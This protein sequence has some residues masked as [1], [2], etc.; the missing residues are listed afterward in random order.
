M[1][2]LLT[3]SET[4]NE[5]SKS[6]PDEHR[7]IRMPKEFRDNFMFSLHDYVSLRGADGKI[8]AL[9]ILP[10]YKED[11][12][13]DSSSAYLTSNIF[14]A[15]KIVGKELANKKIQNVELVQGITL[16][17]DPEL[18]LVDAKGN[19]IYANR[20][21]RRFSNVGYDGPMMEFRPMPSTREEG[22]TNNLFSLIV[23]A[24]NHL[25]TFA[26]VKVIN[27][28]PIPQPS[29][30]R[31]VAASSYR[32]VAA[33]F[34]LHFGLP[35]Q[36]LG[37][38]YITKLLARQIVKALDFYVGIPAIIP[39]GGEDFFR[40][41]FVGSAYGKPGNFILDN[42]TLEYRLPGGTLMRHPILAKGILGLGAAVI[43][44]VVSRVKK[45][46]ENYSFLE[47]MLPDKS[48]SIIYP[49]IPPP[50][51]IYQTIVSPNIVPAEAK[52]DIII[53]DVRQMIGYRARA[54]AIEEY[55]KHVK[56][57][58]SSDVE[59]NWRNHYEGQQRSVDVH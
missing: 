47:S 18:F 57:K 45:A 56:T 43:E 41:T 21:F 25:N 22:V 11:A 12:E 38:Q 30:I 54:H 10:A 34:H 58:F 3:V 19:I 26:G 52:L 1:E 15:T 46:T 6:D 55:F 2:I 50:T 8:I 49:N 16:G 53:N 24:R 36:L 23:Q 17:C 31:M 59:S 42:R 28:I 35:Q 5:R 13:T 7:V 29:S 9:R 39:E 51:E 32:S 27:S 40:R 4:M 44:D 14:A 48:L 37:G 20:F 33:G